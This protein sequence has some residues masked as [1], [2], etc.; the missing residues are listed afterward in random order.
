[1]PVLRMLQGQGGGFAPSSLPVWPT[2][3]HLVKRLWSHLP[4]RSEMGKVWSSAFLDGQALE[5]GDGPLQ[6]V[7]LLL[8]E[9]P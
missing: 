4:S 5:K 8:A 9:P 7:Q 2:Q 6:K 1:M 3:P